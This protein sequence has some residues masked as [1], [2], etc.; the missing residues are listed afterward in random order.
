MM[1]KLALPAVAAAVCFVLAGC[2]DRA[3]QLEQQYN[4]A[5]RNR[6]SPRELCNMLKGIAQ[7]HL[8]AGREEKYH[9]ARLTADIRCMAADLG[10]AR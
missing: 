9:Q 7:A 4:I 6:A 1:I 3:A 8:E 2:S 10:I 5:A